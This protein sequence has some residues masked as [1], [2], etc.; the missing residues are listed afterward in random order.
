MA[1]FN[2]TALDK[3]GHERKG[4]LEGD[5]AKQVRQTLRE[6]GLIPI[7]VISVKERPIN[8]SV[9]FSQKKRVNVKDL[10]LLTQQ[11]ST[12]LSSGMPLEETLQAVAE[13]T[14]KP[15]VKS[16][17]LGV[18]SK[19]LEGHSL[20][21]G[22][23]DFP[24]AFPHLYRAT[25]SSGEQ[26]G[27][28]DKVL[29]RLAIYTEKQHRMRQKIRQAMI[30]PMLMT[31]VS[32]SILSFLLAYVVPK[33]VD[34]FTE[35]NQKL[36]LITQFLIS[37]S[38]LVKHYGIY[39]LILISL[40]IYSFLRLL[41][42]EHFRRRFHGFLLKIPLIGNMLIVVNTARFARTFGILFSASVPVLEAMHVAS[43]LIVL[44]PMREAVQTAITRVREGSTIHHALQQIGYFPPM[45]VHLIASG[46]SSGHLEIMLERAADM[47]E[48]DVSALIE[49]LLT[50]FEPLLILFMGAIVLF[51]VLAILL[52]IFSLEQFVG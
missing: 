21:A 47:Q 18:R 11:L 27:H 24:Q 23:S 36:P 48:N 5:T 15:H 19:V 51:I 14:E 20:A 41:K 37:T 35:S 45:S 38:N 34:V 2:Y 49:N 12:L 13:Q 8:K 26:S 9:L 16:V 42:R 52:P 40:L 31:I 25:V 22:M 1:A 4:Y 46:E 30:Y 28:L 50:L 3:K 39:I 6:Q 17:I 33:I 10:A 32:L 43:E 29:E 44:L 7:Q